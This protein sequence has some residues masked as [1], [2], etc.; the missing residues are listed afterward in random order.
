LI[1]I[2]CCCVAIF[3]FS[4]LAASVEC[5]VDHFFSSPTAKAIKQQNIGLIVNHTSVNRKLETTFDLF[6][7]N[8]FQVKALYTPEHGLQGFHEAGEKVSSTTYRGIPVYSLYGENR[9]P[10]EKMLAGIDVLIFDIQDIGVRSYTYASTL[11]Y[12]MEEAAKRHLRLIVLDRPNPL[13]GV[14]VDGMMLDPAWRSFVGYVN[15]PYCHGMTIG[16][17]AQ[18][19]NEEYQIKADLVVIPMQGWKRKMGYADTRLPWV[20]TSPHIPEADTPYYYATTGL[21]GELGLASIGI[22]YTLPFKVI[23][24]PWIDAEVLA[25]HLNSQ[26]LPGVKF[27]PYHYKPFYGS[28][29]GIVCHGVLIKV[30]DFHQFK[31][32]STQML[33]MGIL[34]SLYPKPFEEAMKKASKSAKELFCKCSGTQEILNILEKEKYASWKL[35]GLH[36]SEREAFILKRKKYLIPAYD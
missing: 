24:A 26:R 17:L 27:I 6:L 33:L 3:F 28:F 36:L 15:V 7:K 11:F 35:M 10:N 31:P 4:N 16:E 29:K 21:I 9:R 12:V 5:G 19:F 2:V 14:V 23:G 22:G 1:R 18:F 32:A 30:L 34:K 25:S 8:A 20:P 13:G